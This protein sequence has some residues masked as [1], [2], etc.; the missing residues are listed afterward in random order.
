MSDPPD[1]RVLGAR[2]ALGAVIGHLA[3]IDPEEYGKD[4]ALAVMAMK[5]DLSRTA[6]SWLVNVPAEW[7]G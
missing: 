3:T 2:M 6:G 5:I 1:E 7:L 4:H